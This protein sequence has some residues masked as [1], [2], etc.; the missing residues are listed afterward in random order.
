MNRAFINVIQFNNEQK[1]TD[2]EKEI[3]NTVKASITEISI[4]KIASLLAH[5]LSKDDHFL[6][7]YKH[8]RD[9][10]KQPKQTEKL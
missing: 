2:M 9:G 7:E 3:K 6:K 1:T 4:D 5:F 10:T 8:Y